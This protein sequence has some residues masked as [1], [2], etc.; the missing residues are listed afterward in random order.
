VGWVATRGQGPSPPASDWD[1]LDPPARCARALGLIRQR[2][3]WP[4]HCR[5]RVPEDRVVAASFPP[6]VGAPPWDAPRIEVYLTP[7]DE[8]V[9]VARAIAHEMGHMRHTRE[10]TF[11]AEWLQARR[12]RGDTDW[13]I[14]VEDYAEVFAALYGPR[15]DWRAPT[16]APS[17]A[18]LD[19]LQSRFFE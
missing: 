17:A 19:A 2:N 6:P 4:L 8:A 1:R 10:P 18:D 3:P 5:W 15:S 9:E 7:E 14:W 11:V 12:L 13:Q 16:P